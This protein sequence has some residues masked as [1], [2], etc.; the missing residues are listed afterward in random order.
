LQPYQKQR[1]KCIGR[2]LQ[3]D[4]QHYKD[5]QKVLTMLSEVG[6]LLPMAMLLQKSKYAACMEMLIYQMQAAAAQKQLIIGSGHPVMM[7]NR[8][9]R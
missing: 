1:A 3:Q 4:S 7:I 2:W 8:P 5:S 6:M 9:S